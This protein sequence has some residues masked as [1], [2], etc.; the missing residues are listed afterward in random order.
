MEKKF[1]HISQL[2][3]ESGAQIH[4]LNLCYHILNSDGKGK[5]IWIFHALTASS[6]PMEW[7]ND[8]VENAN[9]IDLEND[10]IICAN[11]LG[12]CYGTTWYRVL[13]RDGQK[14]ELPLI[15]VRDNIKAFDLLRQELD[16]YKVDIALGGSLG[17]S[18]LLEWNIYSKDLFE[19]SIFLACSPHESTWGKAAHFAQR[20]AIESDEAFKRGDYLNVKEGLKVAR[21]IGMLT[22]RSRE[23]FDHF[24]S[25]EQ[26]RMEDFKVESY[27]KY[28]EEKFLERFNAK[29]YYILSK[30]LDTHDLSRDRF[31]L[32][33]A[34]LKINSK[35][36]VIGISS[37]ML[38]PIE[39]QRVLAQGIP[40][41]SLKEIESIYGH[42]GF[43][44]EHKIINETIRD[45]LNN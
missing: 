25:D 5:T 33:D 34:L 17:G 8:L 16:I 41:A 13:D 35:S 4:D 43:L 19:R 7:W 29:A 18:Q 23:C 10:R 1:F 9:W 15:S 12:S 31:S 20:R 21:T 40:N 42:D 38:C 45:F 44:V 14:L 11:L 22:Y 6:N 3:L 2:G 27:L 24:Q 28:Q 36:L 39:D 37:D 32:S 26:S 30:T